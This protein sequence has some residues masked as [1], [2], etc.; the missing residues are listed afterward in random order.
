MRRYV[1]CTNLRDIIPTILQQKSH[2]NEYIIKLGIDEGGGFLKVCIGVMAPLKRLLKH[3]FSKDS[4][5][6]HLLGVM[7]HLLKLLK[8]TWPHLEECLKHL[9]VAPEPGIA[10]GGQ[11]AGPASQKIFKNLE[12]L[13][14]QAENQ[15]AFQTIAVVDTLKMF[16][17]IVKSCFGNSLII[18]RFSFTNLR[19]ATLSIGLGP[20]RNSYL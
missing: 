8:S 16:K 17:E 12:L 3:R 15:S 13:Q 4:E 11:F 6:H 20:S 5:L 19:T 14:Q 9:G 7:N 18:M 10:P 1:N 2:I